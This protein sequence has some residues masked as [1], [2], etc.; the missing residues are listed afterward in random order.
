MQQQSPN[1][2]VD[3]ARALVNGIEIYYEIHGR[4]GR[5]PLVLL[6][7]GG[8]TIDSN[9]GRILPCLAR[10]HRVIALEEQGHG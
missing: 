3:A 4:S 6:H 5:V 1:T 8:S 2:R 9:C 7:G 10:T